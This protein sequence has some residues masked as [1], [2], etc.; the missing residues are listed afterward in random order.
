MNDTYI[1]VSQLNRYI[2]FLLSDNSKLRGVY[3]KG[4]ISNFNR[5]YRSGHCYLSLKDTDASVKA[6]MFKTVAD[7]VKFD[8]EDG[9]SVIVRADVTLYERDG[10]YQLVISDMIPY[11]VGELSLAFEQLKAKLAE[12]GMFEDSYKKPIPKFPKRIAIISS[13]TG[14]AI[15]D[16]FNILKRRMPYVEVDLYPVSVQ[17][18]NT[19]PEVIKALKFIEEKNNVDEII[20]A[21][22][23]G[24]KE[25]LHQFNNET[26]AYAVFN[27]K[28]PI[29]SAIGHEIDFTICDFVA[30]LRAPT[31]S[32]AAELAGVSVSEISEKINALLKMADFSA[33]KKISANKYTVQ[34]VYIPKIVGKLNEIVKK[35][36]QKTDFL[37]K[38]SEKSVGNKL[39][40]LSLRFKGDCARLESLNPF[41]VLKRG[42][43]I[44]NNNKG[45]QVV[46]VN[47]VTSGEDI[48]VKLRDGN[49]T[50]TIMGVENN[51]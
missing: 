27:C 9:M 33:R 24:S 4:E 25:D 1:T 11:G 20:I 49:I 3:I 2:K 22:G 5:N 13:K 26:L 37:V 44:V 14:A 18:E 6:V 39:S 30:D 16:I 34:S 28:I 35:N 40:S 43:A 8:V 32:A 17:G 21:R 51:A 31:P 45:N 10:T 41:S 42:Y 48:S 36:R 7:R 12:K 29:I 47:Q 46:S 23:G 50:A 15:Q 38:Y 19:A